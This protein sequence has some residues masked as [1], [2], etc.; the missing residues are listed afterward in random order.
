LRSGGGGELAAEWLRL[1]GQGLGRE[2]RGR[3]LAESFSATREEI[4]EA[5]A[6]IPESR[7]PKVVYLYHRQGNVFQVAGGKTTVDA[8]IRLAGGINPASSL[9]AY[10]S[11]GAE[12][13][14]AWA[15]DILLLGNFDK[16]LKPAL[17]FDGTL[18]DSLPAVKEK[19]VYLYP[20]GGFRWDPPSQETPLAWRWLFAL[21]HPDAPSA[22]LR[23]EIVE[24]YRHL[25]DHALD[26]AEIDTILR[27]SD[28]DGSL[29]YSE[30]FG[31]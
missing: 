21:F 15:P 12:Q 22:S 17:F 28:N 18:F 27:M 20:R 19:R 7:R 9:N 2:A 8:D 13:I 5:V 1:L 6:R 23:A 3:S 29:G 31:R 30:K 16:D 11:V 4:V 10:A 14:L 25:Y 26:A 24:S